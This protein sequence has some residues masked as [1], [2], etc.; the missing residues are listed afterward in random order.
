MNNSGIQN[1]AEQARREEAHL[2]PALA[3]LIDR[4]K[5]REQIKQAQ[6]GEAPDVF[7]LNFHQS[8]KAIRL[9][10]N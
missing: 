4:V 5:W 9:L 2:H 8:A 10:N 3:E 1:A 6:Q 7:S